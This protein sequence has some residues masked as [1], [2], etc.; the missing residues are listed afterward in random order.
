MDALQPTWNRG[1]FIKINGI[2]RQ[3]SLRT[4]LYAIFGR[5]AVPVFF[6]TPLLNAA[7][8]EVEFADL[9]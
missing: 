1:K 8:V 9:L 6:P 7:Q 3:G 5:V 2:W 4:F